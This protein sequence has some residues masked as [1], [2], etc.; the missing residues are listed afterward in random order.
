MT[1]Q[2]IKREIQE[3]RKAIIPPNRH[4]ENLSYTPELLRCSKEFEMAKT[5]ARQRLVDSGVSESELLEHERMDFICDAEVM[6]A[7]HNFLRASW[8]AEN[9]NKP[10]IKVN[11]LFDCPVEV[12]NYK[13]AYDK[14]NEFS[15]MER[16]F[17]VIEAEYEL[18]RDVTKVGV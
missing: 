2:Q 4:S 9:P 10:Q 5:R 18:L 1:L 3:L 7:N 16:T 15:G 14:L 13:R 6:D 8:N 12:E 11:Y 17:E